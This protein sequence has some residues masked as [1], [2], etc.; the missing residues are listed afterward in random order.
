M[1]LRTVDAGAAAVLPSIH[2]T[3]KKFRTAEDWP[4]E[5]GMARDPATGTTASVAPAE[6]AVP[7]GFSNRPYNEDLAPAEKRD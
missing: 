4:G 1:R 3:K 5:D 7:D 2:H 6:R